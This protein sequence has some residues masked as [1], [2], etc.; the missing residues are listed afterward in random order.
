MCTGVIVS[1]NTSALAAARLTWAAPKRSMNASVHVIVSFDTKAPQVELRVRGE[2]NHTFF[3]Q[4][5]VHTYHID[6][7]QCTCDSFI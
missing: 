6:E 1:H 5:D 7:R 3:S 4:R 2:K